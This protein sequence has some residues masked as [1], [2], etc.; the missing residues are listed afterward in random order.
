MTKKLPLIT[1]I[2]MILILAACGS[3][4]Q[5]M[6]SADIA[7]TAIAD[8]WISITQTQAALP[9]ATPMPPTF[10]PEPTLTPLPTLP[11][12]STLPPVTLAAGPTTDPCNQVA[13]AEPK[14]TLINVELKNESQGQANLAFGMNTPNDKGECVTYSFGLGKG[15]VVAAKVLAGCYWGYAWI[16]GDEPSVARTGGLILCLTD[17]NLIYH[18]VVSKER[19]EFK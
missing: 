19:V 10:T 15:N 7:N 11:P 5:T 18:V 17:T 1:S 3:A 4:E 16:T 12:L 8:A 13:P 2:L 14:G 9:T 6:S